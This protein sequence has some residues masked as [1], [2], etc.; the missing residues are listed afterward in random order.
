MAL[1]RFWRQGDG[2]TSGA[3][4][5]PPA[6]AEDWGRLAPVA[7]RILMKILYG[8]RNARPNILNAVTQLACFFTKWTSL[9]DRRIHCLVLYIHSTYNYR[10]LG[11][12][13]DAPSAL[14]PHLFADADFAK[15][16]ATRRST[17]GLHLAM[18]GPNR[19]FAIS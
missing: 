6:A 9:C 8:A 15:C 13:G 3:A 4:S 1:M 18:R 7:A 19:R 2:A 17:S 14:Q 5:S 10:L 12:I 16:L 11:W